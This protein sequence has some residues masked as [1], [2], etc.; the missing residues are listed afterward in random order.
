M[1]RSQ[2]T[3][4]HE[5]DLILTFLMHLSGSFKTKDRDQAILNDIQASAQFFISLLES[6]FYK[7]SEK[8]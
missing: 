5:P 2:M 6:S 4:N 7:M 3:M 1:L 8:L